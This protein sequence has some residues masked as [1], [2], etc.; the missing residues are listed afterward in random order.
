MYEEV[1]GILHVFL[2]NVIRDAVVYTEHSRRCTCTAMDVVY[3]LRRQG[4]KLYGFD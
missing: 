3:A 2:T 1:R 4:R